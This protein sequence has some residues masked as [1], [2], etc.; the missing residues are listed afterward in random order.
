MLAVLDSTQVSVTLMI[1]FNFGWKLWLPRLRHMVATQNQQIGG[2]FLQKSAWSIRPKLNVQEASFRSM[3][4]ARNMNGFG[5]LSV[6]EVIERNLKWPAEL[7][8]VRFRV[9]LDKKLKTT[10]RQ[11]LRVSQPSLLGWYQIS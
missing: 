7:M 8:Y 9:A 1:R 4:R 5:C 2:R 3:K 11:Q 10:L 6:D